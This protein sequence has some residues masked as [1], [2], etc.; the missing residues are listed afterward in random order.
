MTDATLVQAWNQYSAVLSERAP[1][2][3][4]AV[5]PPAPGPPTVCQELE[6]AEDD[7][8]TT[9]FTLHDGTGSDLDTGMVLPENLMLSQSAAVISTRMIR[10][11]WAGQPVGMTAE[12]EGDVALAGEAMGTW[13]PEY[14]MIAEDAVAGGLF[15]DLRNGPLHGCVRRWDKG[16]ADT[17]GTAGRSLAALIKQ[18]SRA[19]SSDTGLIDDLRAVVTDGAVTWEAAE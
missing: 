2:S 7:V 19:L 5:R 14:L 15:L 9:W 13:L 11:I 17:W 6:L 8:V 10:E 16:E 4:A 3:W 1:A 12:T 18:V